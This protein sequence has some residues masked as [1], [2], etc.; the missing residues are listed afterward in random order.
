[1][2]G[3]LN[4]SD[5]NMAVTKRPTVIYNVF[6]FVTISDLVVRVLAILPKVCR[7]KPG[8]GQWNLKGDRSLSLDFLQRGSK[9][10]SPMSQDFT[11]Y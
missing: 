11:A 1:M 4:I 2:E 10:V 8:Q 3:V 9:A 5:T 6:V 7:F